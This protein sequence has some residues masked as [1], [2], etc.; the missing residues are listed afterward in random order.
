MAELDDQDQLAS[1]SEA[2]WENIRRGFMEYVGDGPDGRPRYRLTEAGIRH[3][4]EL[5]KS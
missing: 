1:V 3:V 5:I 2:I 4:E